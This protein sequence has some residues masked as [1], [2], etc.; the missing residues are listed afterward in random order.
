MKM[1][2]K[3]KLDENNFSLVE[4]RKEQYTVPNVY[5]ERFN[6]RYRLWGE[7]KKKKKKLNQ[8]ERLSK[9]VY[10]KFRISVFGCKN[11]G[12]KTFAKSKFIYNPSDLDY[13]KTIG[14]EISTKKVEIYEAEVMLSF[15]IFSPEQRFWDNTQKHNLEVYVRGSAGAV[16]M[17]DIT[18]PISLDRASQWIQIIK[19]NAEDIPILLLGNKL[20]LEE[21]REVSKEQ[22]KKFKGDNIISSSMEIS[23]KTGENVEK[24]F[25]N[26]TCMVLKIDPKETLEKM[27]E[28]KRDHFIWIID[29]AIKTKKKKLEGKRKLKKLQKLWRKNYFEGTESFEEYLD[30]QKE[31]V[32]NL[33]E[34]KNELVN[35]KELPEI[36]KVWEKVKNLL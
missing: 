29:R 30:T 15:F 24:M 12:K 35:A 1:I 20:D 4:P 6:N 22:V 3:D 18:N 28:E 10:K 34:Y 27:L 11:V 31:N 25:F 16:I 19:N 5:F 36:S 32:L 14:I 21:Q 33:A 17:Y 8:K 7:K 26:L 2:L 9:M 13:M 23:V